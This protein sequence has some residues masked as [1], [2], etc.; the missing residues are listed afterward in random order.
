MYT[1][2]TFRDCAC[3]HDSALHDDVCICYAC[4]PSRAEKALH[5]ADV[6]ADAI[7]AHAPRA[8]LVAVAAYRKARNLP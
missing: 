2:H 6:L 5:A 3:G 7:G 8:V 1:Y 4:N